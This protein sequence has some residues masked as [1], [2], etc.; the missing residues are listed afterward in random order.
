MNAKNRTKEYVQLI[1]K[2]IDMIEELLYLIQEDG[3]L[4]SPEAEADTISLARDISRAKT[5]IE[6]LYRR[7]IYAYS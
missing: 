5:N 6:L 3:N 4:D 2:H 7:L 1:K